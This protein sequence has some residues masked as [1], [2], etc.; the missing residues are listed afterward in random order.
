MVSKFS[1]IISKQ[2]EYDKKDLKTVNSKKYALK[3]LL[4]IASNV[5]LSNK[6]VQVVTDE[7]IVKVLF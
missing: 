5:D 6:S 4:N 7:I 3:S 1:E 2:N